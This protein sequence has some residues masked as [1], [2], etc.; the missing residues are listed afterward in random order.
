MALDYNRFV[1]I[2]DDDPNND[3]KRA[4]HRTEMETLVMGGGSDEE[5]TDS[6]GERRVDWQDLTDMVI[7]RFA[8]H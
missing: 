5:D 2:Y 4:G 3:V 8:A 1:S 6:D 7:E